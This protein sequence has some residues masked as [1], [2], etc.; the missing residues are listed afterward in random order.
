[1]KTIKY[2]GIGLLCVVSSSAYG[3]SKKDISD[4]VTTIEKNIADLAQALRSGNR[5]AGCKCGDT[6]TSTPPPGALTGNS[7]ACK[8]HDAMI[9]T[10]G[11]SI[12]SLQFWQKVTGA[13]LLVLIGCEI[14]K[15]IAEGFGTSP[16]ASDDNEDDKAPIGI[17]NGQAQGPVG[18]M[19]SESID[20]VSAHK[21]QRPPTPA[22]AVH[23]T[24]AGTD[25]E[26]AQPVQPAQ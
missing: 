15:R 16:S 12:E 14:Y 2:L 10:Q 11:K 8:P 3:M 22:P 23:P 4:R 1:M 25:D 6:S 20:V 7:C 18:S 26:P 5:S 19:A 13:G 9:E 17:I 21:P 24:R